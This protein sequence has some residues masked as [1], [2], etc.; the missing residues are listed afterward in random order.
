MAGQLVNEKLCYMI[1]SVGMH[2]YVTLHLGNHILGKLIRRLKIDILIGNVKTGT[3]FYACLRHLQVFFLL[4]YPTSF[5][6]P[7]K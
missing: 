7:S 5:V 2:D 4:L 6:L 3:L 1:Q